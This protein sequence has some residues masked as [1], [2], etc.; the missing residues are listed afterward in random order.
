MLPL[1]PLAALVAQAPAPVA[2]AGGMMTAVTA[3]PREVRPGDSVLLTWAF[4]QIPQIRLEPGGMVLPGKYQV[5]LRP[6]YTTTYRVFDGRPGGAE[7]GHAD[8]RVTP[9]MALGDPARICAFEASTKAV[10]P[11]E[12]VVLRWECAGSA[13]VRLEPGGLELDG[14]SEVTVTPLESTRYTITANNAAGGQS[15]TVEVSVLGHLAAALPAPAS[16]CTFEASRAVVKPGEQV[17]LRWLCQGNA[18]VRLEPGG[19][20]LDGQSSIAVVPDK[21]TVYTLSV[22]NLMGGSSRSVEVRVEAPRRVL[23]E[24]DLESAEEAAKPLDRMDVTEALHWGETKR[25]AAPEG[26]W[27]LRLVVSGRADGLRTVARAAGPKASEVLV[28]PFLRKDGLRFWQA[29]YG[30]YP[31]RAKAWKA[32]RTAPS[33]LRKAFRDAL[34]QRM[35]AESAAPP[36]ETATG[37]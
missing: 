20:E 11:G 30:T 8:V 13:K 28:L 3:E 22:S 2:P 34:P 26:S 25:G 17:D 24:K 19:L 14:K 36:V 23:T 27:T 7:L 32:W 35:P 15:R 10:L 12:P 29:C 1:L 18:R 16:V 31:S 9:G 21:T 6:A 5:T 37:E 4:P 33:S